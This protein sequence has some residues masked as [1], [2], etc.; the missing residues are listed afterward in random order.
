MTPPTN[1][2][3]RHQ[4]QKRV[5]S[6][7]ESKA[8]VAHYLQRR[9]V[10]RAKID[11]VETMAHGTLGLLSTVRGYHVYRRMWTLVVGKSLTASREYGN[12]HDRHAVALSYPIPF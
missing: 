5:G 12:V 11:G 4:T 10:I 3:K 1:Q 6:G 2:G 7:N 9:V 8:Q